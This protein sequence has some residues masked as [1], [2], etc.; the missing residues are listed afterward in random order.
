[1]YG[2]LFGFN[3]IS[4]YFVAWNYFILFILTLIAQTPGYIITIYKE[5]ELSNELLLFAIIAFLLGAILYL[6]YG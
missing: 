4:V 1:M 2:F 3:K 5:D 6:I